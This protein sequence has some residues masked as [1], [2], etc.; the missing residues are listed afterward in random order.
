MRL[1]RADTV[2][3]QVNRWNGT[4]DMADGFPARLNR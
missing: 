1:Y 3:I 4:I 2:R